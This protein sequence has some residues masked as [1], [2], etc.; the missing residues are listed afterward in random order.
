VLRRRMLEGALS[1]L[2]PGATG[3]PRT[4]VSGASEAVCKLEAQVA[5]L[6][7]ELRLLRTRL[8]LAEG[9]AAEAV[10]LRVTHFLGTDRRRRR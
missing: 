6:E 7:G 1:A 3:R 8:E 2:E 10:R 4:R 5:A 9:P